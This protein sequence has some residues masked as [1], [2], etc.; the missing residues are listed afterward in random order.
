LLCFSPNGAP[1]DIIIEWMRRSS[2]DAVRQ[3]RARGLAPGV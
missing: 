3:S 2:F 1:L